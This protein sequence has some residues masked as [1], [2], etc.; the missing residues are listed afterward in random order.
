MQQVGPGEAGRPQDDKVG[1]EAMLIEA[2]KGQVRGREEKMNTS[3]PPC[4][5]RTHSCCR[6]LEK[7]YLKKATV[8]ALN[9][10]RKGVSQT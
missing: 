7:M 5:H 2:G 10:L 6:T 1:L 9:S 3:S 8:H 4:L